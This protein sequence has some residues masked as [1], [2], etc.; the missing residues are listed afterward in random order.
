M[1]IARTSE[2]EPEP[3]T[4][5]T[6][7]GQVRRRDLGRIGAPEG[8]ALAVSFEAGV[9]TDWHRHSAGQVLYVLDGN[10]RVGTRDGEVVEIGEGDLVEAPPG[11]EHW[12]GAAERAPVT[13]LAL[14]FGETEWL[15]P[16]SQ[17]PV[18]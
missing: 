7:T 6:F 10:G 8:S 13:H 18:S 4:T 2:V 12:H 3:M 17:D 11:E 14:S 16:V 9:R 5:D 1:R 15:E